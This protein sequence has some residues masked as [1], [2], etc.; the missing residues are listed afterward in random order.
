MFLEVSKKALNYAARAETG[1]YPLCV[2]IAKLIFKY[3]IYLKNKEDNVIIKQALIILE[4]TPLKTQNAYINKLNEVLQFSNLN[5][6]H[7]RRP[8][9]EHIPEII[10]TLTL[11]ALRGGGGQIDLPS[12]FLALNFCS[13]TDCQKL[14]HN[15]SLFVNT[16]FDTN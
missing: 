7:P 1:R 3:Y 5:L 14:W 12:I 16:S 10:S 11:E 9:Y 15:C 13:L 6:S 2:I 8:R 4:S